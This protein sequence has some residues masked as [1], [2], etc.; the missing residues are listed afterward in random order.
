M[1]NKPETVT[2]GELLAEYKKEKG[3]GLS[4]EFRSRRFIEV[5]E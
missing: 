2:F 4:K 5:K 1:T 3:W